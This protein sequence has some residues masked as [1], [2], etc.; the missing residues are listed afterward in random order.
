MVAG[1]S[2]GKIE[3]KFKVAL[4]REGSTSK[5]HNCVSSEALWKPVCG[6]VVGQFCFGELLQV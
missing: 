5:A 2:R 4:C 3:L 1:F 6:T